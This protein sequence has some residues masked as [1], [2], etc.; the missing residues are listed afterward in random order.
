ME[1]KTVSFNTII[2]VRNKA[3][4]RQ[5]AFCVYRRSFDFDKNISV[6]YNADID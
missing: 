4:S 3:F 5:N 2:Y 6:L 1:R